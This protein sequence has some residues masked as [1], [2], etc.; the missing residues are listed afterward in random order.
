[1][2]HFVGKGNRSDSQTMHQPVLKELKK[3]RKYASY[4][5]PYLFPPVPTRNYNRVVGAATKIDSEC[6]RWLFRE[7]EEEVN[8]VRL[9]NWH[10]R[11]NPHSFRHALGTYLSREKNMPVQAIAKIL[12]HRDIQTTAEF[13]CNDD[14]LPP[15]KY[16][17]G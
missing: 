2:V 6:V 15:S 16:L 11:L 8:G 4:E 3:L 14:P 7:L 5:G 13:Y 1:M 12:R 10:V 17:D 9:F